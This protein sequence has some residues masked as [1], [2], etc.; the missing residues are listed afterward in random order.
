MDTFLTIAQAAGGAAADAGS[1]IAEGHAEFWLEFI[2][3]VLVLL[4]F[5]LFVVHR[6]AHKVSMKEATGW[7]IFWVALALAFWGFVGWKWGD[8]KAAEFITAYVL[9][10][11]LSIDNLFI[12]LT[13][14]A[15]FKVPGELRHRVLF[16]GILGALVFRGIFVFV[17]TALLEYQWTFYFFGAILIWSAWKL[18]GDHEDTPPDRTLAYRVATKIFPLVPRYE[19]SRFFVVENGKRYG[20]TLFLVLVI[21]ELTDLVF[22][23]DSVPACLAISKDPFIVYTSNV[24][25]I[26]GLRALFFLLEGMMHSIPGLKVGLALVLLFVGLKMIGVPLG[27]NL[28]VNLHLNP[29]VSL[30][31]ILTLLTGSWAVARTLKRKEATEEQ[32]AADIEPDAPG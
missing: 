19:G 1:A 14:F 16:F 24:F 20:T 15:F 18:M 23:V 30:G 27:D 25:A 10:K 26:L 11:L 17:G 2:G 5:D 6:K 3:L 29:W 7:S 12:F 13:L 8:Q 9:E 32:V 31:I 22:A 4:F 21:V 28:G